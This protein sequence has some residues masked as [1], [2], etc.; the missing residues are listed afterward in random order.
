VRRLPLQDV[1]RREVAVPLHDLQHPV[2]SQRPD[3]LVLEVVDAGEEPERLHSVSVNGLPEPGP[4][5]AA[6]HEPLLG[7]VVQPGQPDP[8]SA[9]AE[10]LHVVSEV[11]GAAGRGDE[12]PLGHEVA[13]QPCGEGEYGGLV[14]GAL[15]QHDGALH[16][17]T[18]IG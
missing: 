11:G 15:D 17:A 12:N 5:E 16:A 10:P 1:E 3:Q 7:G 6:A 2:R 8:E 4:P 9:R 13:V 18:I 14:A